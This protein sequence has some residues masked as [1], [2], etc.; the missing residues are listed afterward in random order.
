MSTLTDGN[1][2]RGLGR[3]TGSAARFGS[4]V[5]EK[6]ENKTRRDNVVTAKVVENIELI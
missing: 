6:L 3:A 2:F 5:P 4:E 1:E